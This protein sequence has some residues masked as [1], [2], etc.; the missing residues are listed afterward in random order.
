VFHLHCDSP[1]TAHSES[2]KQV[3]NVPGEDRA[4]LMLGYREQMESM[5]KGN[6]PGLERRFALQDAFEFADYSNE[7]LLS[8]LH[9]KLRA[10]DLTAKVPDTDHAALHMSNHV[11]L[12]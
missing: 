5:L 7:E 8:I 4:V 6:N 11:K 1:H 9:L 12:V 10:E 3:Q 2:Y